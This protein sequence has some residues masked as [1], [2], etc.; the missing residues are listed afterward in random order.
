MKKVNLLFAAAV[1][2][3]T[4]TIGQSNGTLKLSKGQKYQVENTLQTTS[5]TNVQGQAMESKANVTSTYNIEVKDKANNNYNLSNTI[6]RILMDMTMMGTEINFDSNKPEDMSGEMGSALKDYINKPKNVVIDQT[7]KIISTDTQDSSAAGIAKQL[8]FAAS[9]FGAQ[10]AFLALPQN[11]KAGTSWT[12]SSNENGI[13][14]T[15]NYT[16]KDISG[17]IATV[18]FNGTVSTKTT[19]EQQGMEVNTNTTGKFSGEE[20]VDAKT[21]VVQLNTTTGDASGTVSAMGQD[22]PMTSKVTSTTTIKAL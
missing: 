4:A 1:C 13:S 19:M 10:L 8:N 9:G 5:S 7:G 11:A 2:F 20:K 22:F 12:D 6:T 16:I 14:R 17:N 18:S 3:S 15:T 21:G